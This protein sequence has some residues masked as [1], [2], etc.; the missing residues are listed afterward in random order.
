MWKS[1]REKTTNFWLKVM[2]RQAPTPQLHQI[3]CK[4]QPTRYYYLKEVPTPT[5]FSAGYNPQE[6]PTSTDY[7]LLF[8]KLQLERRLQSPNH[9]TK[10]SFFGYLISIFSF[11]SV[12]HHLF[13]SSPI[14]F[15]LYYFYLLLLTR[16]LLMNPLIQT[17]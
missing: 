11:K 17:S 8:I 10:S 9:N 1:I 4:L 2:W 6:A 7:N 3:L 14:M 15:L 12:A 5:K 13:F 16:M